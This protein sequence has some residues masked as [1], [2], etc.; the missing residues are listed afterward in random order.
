MQTEWCVNIYIELLDNVD[1]TP[2]I[3]DHLANEYNYSDAVEAQSCVDIDTKISLDE[4]YT[5][6]DKYSIAGCLN[7]KVFV[8]RLQVNYSTD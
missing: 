7:P 3:M 6:V 4:Q 5:T 2:I 1:N 8:N